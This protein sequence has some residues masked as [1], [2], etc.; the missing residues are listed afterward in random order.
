MINSKYRMLD[1]D[2]DDW[3]VEVI[4]IYEKSSY[5]WHIPFS[6]GIVFPYK[7]RTKEKYAKLKLLAKPEMTFDYPVDKLIKWG[8]VLYTGIRP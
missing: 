4:E 2:S 6:F 8:K 5:E 1:I 7:I 3:I